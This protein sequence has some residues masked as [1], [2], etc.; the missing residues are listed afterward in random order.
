MSRY[1]KKR[2]KKNRYSGRTQDDKTRSTYKW[3]FDILEIPQIVL[4]SSLSIIGLMGFI[5]ERL[6]FLNYEDRPSGGRRGL[7]I[8]AYEGFSAYLLGASLIIFGASILTFYLYEKKLI[9]KVD[10]R[11]MISMGLAANGVVIGFLAF[12]VRLL[13]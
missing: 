2:N 6:Y 9:G 5:Y 3:S 13:K 8:Q 11:H 7:E 12:F 1:K 10:Q 4:G